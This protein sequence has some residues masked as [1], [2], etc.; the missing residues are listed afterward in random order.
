MQPFKEADIEMNQLKVT[1]QK[2]IIS[3]ITRFLCARGTVTS[4]KP[5]YAKPTMLCERILWN[6]YT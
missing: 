5:V 2:L 3:L 6:I 4:H 1:F